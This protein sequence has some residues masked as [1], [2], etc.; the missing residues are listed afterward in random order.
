VHQCYFGEII[1]VAALELN[2]ATIA[3][4]L[5]A[6]RSIWVKDPGNHRSAVSSGAR[7]GI[8]MRKTY[9]VTG[10]RAQPSVA[11]YETGTVASQ[12]PRLSTFKSV[13]S[14]FP[15]T[16]LNRDRDEETTGAA[17]TTRNG[18]IMRQTIISTHPEP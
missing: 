12:P 3:V 6:M 15:Y 14:Q 16:S 17:P 10:M 8:S 5:P 11:K 2:L 9:T 1:I 18:T 13:V 4:N 7:N